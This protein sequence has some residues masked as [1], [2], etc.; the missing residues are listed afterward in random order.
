MIVT[1]PLRGEFPISAGE[2]AVDAASV[3]ELVRKLEV[4][5]P[6]IGDF[7]EAKVSV[8][9]DGALISDWSTPLTPASEV[10]LVPHIA[11]G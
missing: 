9:I 10:M 7:I 8:A 4:D 1:A 2:F 3:F 11:G 6:G 5:S